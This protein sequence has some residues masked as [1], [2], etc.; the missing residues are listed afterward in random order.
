[1]QL[2]AKRQVHS[3]KWKFIKLQRAAQTGELAPPKPMVIYGL[4][5][6]DPYDSYP[7]MKLKSSAWSMFTVVHDADAPP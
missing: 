4:Y 6:D 7:C 3:E 2:F 1:M 5:A